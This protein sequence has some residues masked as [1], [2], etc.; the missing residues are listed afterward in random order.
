MYTIKSKSSRSILSI[1][2]FYLSIIPQQGW[3]K[4]IQHELTRFQCNIQ[5]I[6]L[7]LVKFKELLIK[8]LQFKHHQNFI[9]P[10]SFQ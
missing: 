8:E 1:S 4:T 9:F 2:Q 6:V 5:Q 7:L 3:G 10:S